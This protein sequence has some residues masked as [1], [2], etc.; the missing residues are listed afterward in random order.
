MSDSSKAVFLSYAR[1]DA[2]AARRIA[3]ALRSAGLEVWF[4]ENELRGGDTWDAKIRQQIDACALFVPVISAHTQERTKGYF[5]L[6]WKLA[7]DQTHLLAAGVPFIAPVVIDQTPESAAAVPPEFLKVQWTRLPGA[8]PTPQ[9]VEQVKKLLEGKVA[10]VSDRRT[11]HAESGPGSGASTGSLPV[12]PATRKGIPGWT[13]GALTAVAVGVAVA[14]GVFRKAEPIPLPAPR[15]EAARPG[16]T[17]APEP[18]SPQVD[19]KSVAVLPFVN[20]SGDKDSEYFSDGLTEEILNALARNPD[21]RVAA[22]TSSFAFKGKT[23]PMDEIGRALRAASVI[24]GSVRK[25]GSRVRITVQLINAADGYH[26]WSETFTREMTDIFAVQDEIAGKVAE[27]L[28]GSLVASRAASDAV[29]TKNLA[30]YDAYLRGRAMQTSGWSET[31]SAEA[32]RLFEQALQLDPDYALA[33]ARLAENQVRIWTSGYD[34][35]AA[36]AAQ[37]RQA[38]ASALRLAPDLPEAHLAQA[39]VALI[40]SDLETADRAL[41]RAGQLR[42]NDP[43][44]PAVR[45]RVERARGNR[46]EALAALALRAIEADPQNADT[47][48]LMAGYLTECGHYA[49]ADR[50]CERAWSIAR[51]AEDPIRVRVGNLLPWTGDVGAALALLETT[52]EALREIRFYYRRADLRN[53]RGDA[54]GARTDWERVRT[55][56]NERYGSRSGPR[57]VA[58]DALIRLAKLDGSEGQA[59]RAAAHFTEALA[60]ADRFNRD[61]PEVAYLGVARKAMIHAAQGRRVEALAALEEM[62]RLAPGIHLRYNTIIAESVRFRQAAVLAAL[63]DTDAAVAELRA[64]QEGGVVFGYNLRLNPDYAPLHA[65]PQFQQMM[66][67]CE[68]RA[69]TQ[70]RPKQ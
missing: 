54:A 32:D 12:T 20:M 47:L 38:S 10:P 66:K 55:I 21:L 13:W 56:G 17:H 31:I 40:D 2:A 9:F 33:W 26:V 22:R 27:K 41:D 29:P 61:F 46:G 64:L 6:E 63:G 65:N 51:S 11:G 19:S 18:A 68:A 16:A 30:A 49:N 43:D 45:A 14:L 15:A 62:A 36:V 8:L 44:V 35:T 23:I 7:V 1:D 5:R 3:E 52:P 25:D 59:T 70:P 69:D 67:V 39:L 28:G 57:W 37:A 24:E 42:P 53:M 58:I 50:I 34:R 60:E 4:D 48:V